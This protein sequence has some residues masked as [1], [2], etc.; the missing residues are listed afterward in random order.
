MRQTSQI[1]DSSTALSLTVAPATVTE[2]PNIEANLGLVHFVA[3]QIARGLRSDLELGDLV[4]AGTLGLMGAADSFDSTRGL[5]FSTYAAPRIRGAILDELRK[6]DHAT[7]GQRR[8][9][10]EINAARATLVTE[11][12]TGTARQVAE[13]MGVDVNTLWRW[14]A[15]GESAVQIPIDRPIRRDDPNAITP[16]DLLTNDDESSVDEEMDKAEQVAALRDAIAVLPDR[17]RNVLALSYF[18]GLKLSEIAHV[19]GVTESRVSQIRT[20]ALGRLRQHMSPM[21]AA[22]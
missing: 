12:A 13:R 1:T 17:E 16:L 5:A 9:S 2:T 20:K 18:E 8:K 22:A 14:E 7:R 4:S 11:G 10:R 19:L 3:R 6:M 15:D 21:S